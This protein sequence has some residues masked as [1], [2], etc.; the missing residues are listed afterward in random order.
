MRRGDAGVEVLL[1]TTSAGRWTIPKGVVDLGSTARDSA[2]REAFEEAGVR[3]T[4]GTEPIGSYRYHKWGGE[5]V[6]EVFLLDV[7]DIV[8]HWP[9]HARRDRSW[10]SVEEAADVVAVGGLR[11][12]L[13]RVKT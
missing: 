12:L 5:C 1:V 4:A 2:V 6:V 9:E 11:E 10:M 7:D 3:G 13:L 8:D